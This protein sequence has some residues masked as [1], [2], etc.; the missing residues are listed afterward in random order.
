[1]IFEFESRDGQ[2]L[3]LDYPIGQ[4]PRRVRRGGKAF[5]RIVSRF[6]TTAPTKPSAGNTGYHRSMS[7]PR[8]WPYAPRHDTDGTPLFCN[9]DETRE[10]EKKAADDGEFAHYDR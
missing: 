2:L 7:L 6:Q 3:E 1:M 8:W 5:K 4:A 10:A 9:V